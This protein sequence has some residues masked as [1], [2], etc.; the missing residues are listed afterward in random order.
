MTVGAD[1]AAPQPP[2]D[3][4]GGTIP[5]PDGSNGSD[6][7]GVEGS[8]C[9]TACDCVAGLACLGSKCTSGA[10][11]VYCCGDTSCPSGDVCQDTSGRYARCGSGTPDLAGFDYC[12]L[13]NCSGV[14]GPQ[15]CTN[16]GCTQCIAN[17]K[18]GGGMVCAK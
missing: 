12:G 1:L 10:V 14:N 5:N 16:A 7:G 9:Q 15:V 4:A 18:G 17:P 13:I 8:G 11:P 2:V 3:L 6:D